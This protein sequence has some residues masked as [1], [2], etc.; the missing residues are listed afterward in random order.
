LDCFIIKFYFFIQF[1]F[2]RVFFTSQS[3]YGFSILNQLV[4]FFFL[5]ICFLFIFFFI[6]PFVL[7]YQN[8]MIL[9]N[10]SSQWHKP[11]IM[12]HFLRAT[13]I[14]DTVIFI[15]V[16]GHSLSDL[17]KTLNHGITSQPLELIYLLTVSI[18][19]KY[20]SCINIY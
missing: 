2:N 13:W 17:A 18:M 10:R 16:R 11:F 1:A 7:Y 5:S 4:F 6:V 20:L 15:V 14:Y 9:L 12:L 8:H 19:I 3:S